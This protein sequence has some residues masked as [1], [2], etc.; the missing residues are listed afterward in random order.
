MIIWLEKVF[1]VIID[2]YFPGLIVLGVFPKVNEA[3]PDLVPLQ[4]KY[5]TLSHTGIKGTVF[6]NT[7]DDI[8]LKTTF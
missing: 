3:D 6:Q 1:Q 5:L 2:G 7:A 8:S 4:V